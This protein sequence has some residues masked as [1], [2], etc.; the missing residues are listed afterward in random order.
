MPTSSMCKSITHTCM[1]QEDTRAPACTRQETHASHL[2]APKRCVRYSL[3]RALKDTR[4]HRCVHPQM[5]EPLLLATQRC[6]R[7]GSCKESRPSL[8][9]PRTF[10][11]VL[12]NDQG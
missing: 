4:A 3:L 11:H 2:H 5:H 1:S 10:S 8:A 7:L 6:A 12:P 9:T